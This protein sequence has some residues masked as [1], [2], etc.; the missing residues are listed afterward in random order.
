MWSPPWTRMRC[1]GWGVGAGPV[2]C[3]GCALWCPARS[4]W[5]RPGTRVWCRGLA[6]PAAAGRRG[7]GR[8]RARGLPRLAVGGG[9]GVWCHARGLI[10]V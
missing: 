5:G 1:R 4:M 9:G 2:P 6:V 10:A 8:E 7:A 3:G